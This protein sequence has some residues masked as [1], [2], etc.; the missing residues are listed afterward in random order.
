LVVGNWDDRRRRLAADHPDALVGSEEVRT[1]HAACVQL[2][3]QFVEQR[4]I[5]AE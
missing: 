5:E 1:R 2:G 3:A 4:P